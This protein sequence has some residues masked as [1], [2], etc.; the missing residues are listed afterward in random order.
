MSEFI[1]LHNH[2]H[3]SL[4]DGAA[5]I[6]QIVDTVSEQGHKAFALTDHGNMFGV[7]EFYKKAKAKGFKPIIGCEA[8]I[9]Q[10]KMLDKSSP[11]EGKRNY[12]L[13][14]LAKNEIGYK[15]LMKLTSMGYLDGFYFKPRV[16]KDALRAHSE[17]LIASTACLNGEVTYAASMG[18][19]AK[20]KAAALEYYE[21][22]GDGNFYLE[23]QR[24]RTL[25]GQDIERESIAREVVRKIS[26]ETG[27][28]LVATND[29]HYVNPEHHLAHDALIC[30]GHGKYISD[31]KRL[32]YDTKDIYIKTAD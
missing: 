28:P 24:H 23:L 9:S 12:H 5:K 16:D 14:L 29:A 11:T 32:K 15:N 31:T 25:A 4:L 26:A 3:Y 10:G 2:S 22:F 20:A 30:I 19:Y 27:I 21:I 17:G 6:D 1:H 7:V 13:V 18:D 8:Y